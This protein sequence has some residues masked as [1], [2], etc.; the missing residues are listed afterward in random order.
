MAKEEEKEVIPTPEETPPEEMPG[1]ATTN[2]EELVVEETPEEALTKEVASL[3]ESLQQMEDKFLRAQAE[4]ANITRRNKTEREQLSRFR[5]QDL[6]KGILTS[7]DNLERALAAEVSDEQGTALKKGVEMVLAS[8][9]QALKE[10]GVVE[11]PASGEKFDPNLHQAVQ[12]L[13]ADDEHPADTVV[14]VLQKGYQ[15]HERVLRP[16]MVIVAQ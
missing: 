10:E 2:E 6:A 15:L 3:K 4:I 7:L 8:L 12:T 1:A 9:K 11:I 13:P 14:Q 16:A 5:S